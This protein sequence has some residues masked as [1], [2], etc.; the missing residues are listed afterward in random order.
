MPSVRTTFAIL[1]SCCVAAGCSQPQ[2]AAAAVDDVDARYAPAEY[3]PVEVPNLAKR[4]G[5]DDWPHFLG[6][7]RDSKSAEK[8]ILTDWPDDGPRVVWHR[9]LGTSYGIGSVSRGRFF[10]F[11]RHGDHARLQCLNAESGRLIWWWEYPTDYEDYYG[12]NNGPRCSPVVDGDRVYILGAEGMLHCLRV[13]DGQLFWK[14]DTVKRFGVVQNFFGVGSTP[15]VEGDLLICMIG[16]SPESSHGLGS[17]QLDRVEGNGSGV[18]A[19]DKFTGQVKYQITN[20]L[21]SY[22]SLQLATIGGRRWGFAFARGGLVGFDPAKGQVDF[23]YPWRAE[24]LESVNASTPVVVG[25]EVFIS[26]TYG[27]GSTLL[28]VAPG[29]QRVVWLD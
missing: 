2:P 4:S 27:P 26:E 17:A 10:Q 11:D 7:T 20:E 14:V 19:F 1:L 3:A 23:Q 13:T 6:P 9:S 16:G 29:E 8:E 21:A 28:H 12:Y 24:I 22:A 5:G 25:D 18:V 15:V